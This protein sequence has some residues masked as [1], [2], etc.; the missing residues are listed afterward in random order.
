MI[1]FI[2]H[3]FMMIGAIFLWGWL[4]EIFAADYFKYKNTEFPESVVRNWVVGMWYI[5]LIVFV[6]ISWI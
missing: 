6:I 3:F 4:A 2:I 1:Y 5:A